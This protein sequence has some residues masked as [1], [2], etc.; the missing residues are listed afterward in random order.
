MEPTFTYG[1]IR[2]SF[3]SESFYFSTSPSTLPWNMSRISGAGWRPFSLYLGLLSVYITLTLMFYGRIPLD[4][5]PYLH[6]CM[7]WGL[8]D[9]GCICISSV[10][11]TLY[12]S[13]L[14]AWERKIGDF[15]GFLIISVGNWERLSQQFL[16]AQMSFKPGNNSNEVFWGEK[17]MIGTILKDN[18]SLAAM[19]RKL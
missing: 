16:V 9:L 1:Y 14:V 8:L 13:S 2:D 15:Y 11:R 4:S 12:Q 6:P 17:W 10:S 7:L 5:W 18:K 3:W 19:Y